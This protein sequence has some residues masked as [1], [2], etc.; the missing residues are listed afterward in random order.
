MSGGEATAE[1]G[2][3]GDSVIHQATLQTTTSPVIS[4][5]HLIKLQFLFP[6][7]SPSQPL[8]LPF[9]PESLAPIFNI[10]VKY[11]HL[12]SLTRTLAKGCWGFCSDGSAFSTHAEPLGFLLTPS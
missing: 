12:L 3:S 11:V 7:L 5:S 2:K 10:W 4:A 6:P 9:K 1:S 8:P